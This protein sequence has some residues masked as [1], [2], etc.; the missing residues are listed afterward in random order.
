MTLLI[1]LWVGDTLR[2]AQKGCSRTGKSG[3]YH[4]Q[5][6]RQRIGSLLE[7]N[8]HDA[9]NHLLLFFSAPEDRWS[10]QGGCRGQAQGMGDGEIMKKESAMCI[11]SGCLSQ[12]SLGAPNS[13]V[14]GSAW[15]LTLFW[16]TKPEAGRGLST[17]I[18]K[19]GEKYKHSGVT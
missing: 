18:H 8:Q 5:V 15:F 13:S 19:P 17:V 9:R 6:K 3:L 14:L 7:Y 16:T 12:S 10:L 4:L 2:W 11:Y 1:F